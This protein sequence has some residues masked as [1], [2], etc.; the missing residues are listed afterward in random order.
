MTRNPCRA[1]VSTDAV[2]VSPCTST[3]TPRSSRSPN[4]TV[5]GPQTTA[6]GVE[7]VTLNRTGAEPP[8]GVQVAVLDAVARRA[9]GEIEDGP[10]VPVVPADPHAGQRRYVRAARVRGTGHGCGAGGSGQV[11]TGLRR[12]CAQRH[13][14]GDHGQHEQ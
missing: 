6:R 5:P 10:V 2:P 3:W 12:G 14:R 13:A 7:P 4:W 8:R 1:A 9:G 11:G